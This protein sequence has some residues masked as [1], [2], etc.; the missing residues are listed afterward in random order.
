VTIAVKGQI[1]YKRRATIVSTG[2]AAGVGMC[3]GIACKRAGDAD[4][5]PCC[6]RLR[7][8]AI[9]VRAYDCGRV[10]VGVKG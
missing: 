2:N 3:D 1:L 5:C 6:Q 9:K 8:A 10:A 7:I 4:G